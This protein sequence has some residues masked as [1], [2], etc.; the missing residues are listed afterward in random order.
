MD[1]GPVTA[2]AVLFARADSIY[3]QLPGVD[4]YDEARDARTW[5]GGAP[6]VAHPPCRA[7][8]R[9]RR[10]A[11]PLPHE[12][13]LAILAV[14]HVRR[15][16][17]VLEHPEASTLWIEAGLP[18]PGAGMD[19][20][21][22]WTLPVDQFWWGHR[23]RKATWLYIVGIEPAAL[24]GI[25]FDIGHPPCVVTQPPA[26]KGQRRVRKG[27]AG[28][29]PELNRAEREAT[30]PRFASWLVDLARRCSASGVR[31]RA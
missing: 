3:K 12:K 17:G 2:V 15:Y 26:R 8:G 7:W 10:L 19:G 21:G 28:W 23:A 24:P 14:A 6:V 25:P 29:R 30:P 5:A 27:D 20:F 11:R 31:P 18:R 9:L 13:S 1:G 4:V 16:G 22:G